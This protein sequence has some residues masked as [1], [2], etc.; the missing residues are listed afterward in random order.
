[1]ITD[2]YVWLKEML[3]AEFGANHTE[4]IVENGG[5]ALFY[6]VTN[7]N[8]RNALLLAENSNGLATVG[9]YTLE[10]MSGPLCEN[11]TMPE[12]RLNNEP[13]KVQQIEDMIQVVKESWKKPKEGNNNGKVLD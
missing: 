11:F 1:M 3:L 8:G 10:E 4:E 7:D 9:E 2:E 6:K 5:R 13:E 12:Y